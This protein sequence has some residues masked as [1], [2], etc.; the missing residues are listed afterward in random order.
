VEPIFEEDLNSW[1]TPFFM[2]PINT[3]H[4]HRTNYL[5]EHQYGSDFVYDEM[6][7][8]G[9]GEEGKSIAQAIAA[10]DS[11]VK[12]DLKPGEEPTKEKRDNGYYDLL[13]VG[14]NDKGETIRASVKGDRNPGYG[15]TCKIIAENAICL[16]KNPDLA[17]GGILTAASSMGN[18]LLDRLQENA[19]L[20]F[21]L[22]NK[23]SGFHTCRRTRFNSR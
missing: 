5:L 1:W 19:G 13:F 12:S 15:S 9:P 6:Y 18:V 21:T 10:D 16:L 7:L 3:K 22:E 4:I 11:M 17:S 20:S 14:S 8:T 23:Y 2:A